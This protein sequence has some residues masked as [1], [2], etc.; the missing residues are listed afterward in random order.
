[1]GIIFSGI[2][3]ELKKIISD[4]IEKSLCIILCDQVTRGT[5]FL[6]LIPFPDKRNLLSVLVTN[7][8]VLEDDDIAV[9]KK[10]K[11]ILQN[12]KKP[13]KIII[14]RERKTYRSNKYDISRKLHQKF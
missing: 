6:C 5:G 12:N 11:I 4:Q 10:I 1:M 2:S 3:D 14:D 9:N 7:S 13:F 8:H